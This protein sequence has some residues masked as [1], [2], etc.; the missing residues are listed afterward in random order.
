MERCK[1]NWGFIWP[2]EQLAIHAR[3]R[4]WCRG[5]GGSPEHNRR[6]RQNCFLWEAPRLT[7]VV[8]RPIFFDINASL[9][10]VIFW[11]HSGIIWFL[12]LFVAELGGTISVDTIRYITKGKVLLGHVKSTCRLDNATT[13]RLFTAFFLFSLMLLLCMYKDIP[14]WRVELFRLWLKCC[15]LLSTCTDF[16]PWLA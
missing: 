2:I 5:W 3:L 16:L 9:H 14:R 11:H 7:T 12:I 6:I 1:S 8:F 4:C 15:L 10:F 13:A